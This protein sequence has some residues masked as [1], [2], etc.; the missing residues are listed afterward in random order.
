MPNR[1]VRN[2][3]LDICTELI[4]GA[5]DGLLCDCDQDII[6]I[7]KKVEVERVRYISSYMFAI[8]SFG[9]DEYIR[10]SKEKAILR[11]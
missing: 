7:A 3:K 4:G 8:P 2:G 9:Y 5:S 10:I 6:R 1:I 11:G